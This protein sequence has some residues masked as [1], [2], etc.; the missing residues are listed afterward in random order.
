MT[1]TYDYI[2]IGAG[3]A[4]C[5]P[6]NRLSEDPD[7]RI[8]RQ[9]QVDLHPDADGAVHSD[10]LHQVQ[11]EIYAP[12]G[13]RPN[14]NVTT[15]AMTRR[16]LLEGKRAVGVEYEL[17]GEHVMVKA[18]REVLISS[19][20]IGSPHL[21]QRSGIGPAA[22]LQKADVEVLHDLPGLAKTCR[23]T[24]RSISNMPARSRSRS[25]ARWG[26]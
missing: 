26:F 1:E 2:I 9:R 19:C 11:L 8:W 17:G 6:A 15:H 23:I 22:V 13:T 20:P 18:S 10:E 14:L 5:V 16:V 24:R 7:A 3:S 4:G 12:A 25:T 21:L